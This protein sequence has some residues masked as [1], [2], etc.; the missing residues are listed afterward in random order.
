MKNVMC[1]VLDFEDFE[2]TIFALPDDHPLV[3]FAERWKAAG[4]QAWV[5][6]ANDKPYLVE[7]WWDAA[8]QKKVQ[9]PANVDLTVFGC[10]S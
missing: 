8:K 2:Q 7:A 5:D 10:P 4:G 3:A 1:I 6:L 9:L